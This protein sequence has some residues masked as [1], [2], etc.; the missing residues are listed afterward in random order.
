MFNNDEF[1]DS[2]GHIPEETFLKIKGISEFKK[3]DP[4]VQL[5]ELGKVPSKLYLLISGVMRCY[6]TSESGK[7]FNKR[8]F[9]P[10]NFAGSLT[11]LIKNA[12]SE[13]VYET[14]TECSLYEIDYKELKQMCATDIVISNLYTV[15]LEKVFMRYEKRQLELISMN[16]SQRYL[17]LKEDIPNIDKL[18]P[19]Y[20]IASYLSVT[21][22]QMSRIRKKM[23]ESQD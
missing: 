15:I 7:E 22:V 11:A 5:D 1:S 13:V 3:F 19:Q 16:A 20:H 9:F 14:I 4:H 2:F 12:P 6:I 23:K 8:F 10:M 17:K 18:V 21:P